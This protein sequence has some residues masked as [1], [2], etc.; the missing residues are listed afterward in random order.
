MLERDSWL[1]ILD[2]RARSGGGAH[3]FFSSAG[4]A[5]MGQPLGDTCQPLEDTLSQQQLLILIMVELDVVSS[6]RFGFFL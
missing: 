3:G 5:C 4:R 2:L 1:Y 6:Y